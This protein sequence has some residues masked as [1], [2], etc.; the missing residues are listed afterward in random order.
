MLAISYAM[1]DM[2]LTTNRLCCKDCVCAAMRQKVKTCRLVCFLVCNSKLQKTCGMTSIIR[3]SGVDWPSRV[4][5]H[6]ALGMTG[7]GRWDGA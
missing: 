3:Q 2:L 5:R 4:G 7:H 1:A 6:L